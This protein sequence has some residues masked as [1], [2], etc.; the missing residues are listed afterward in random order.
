MTLKVHPELVTMSAHA[1]KRHALNIQCCAEL[2]LL[3]TASKFHLGVLDTSEWVDVV[4]GAEHGGTLML[5]DAAEVGDIDPTMSMSQIYRSPCRGGTPVLEAEAEGEVGNYACPGPLLY[6]CLKPDIDGILMREDVAKVGAFDSP[7][8][9]SYMSPRLEAE[10]ESGDYDCLGP[11]SEGSLERG[12]I[13]KLEDEAEAGDFVSPAPQSY[14]WLEDTWR[15]EP[16]QLKCRRKSDD[17]L[18]KL[19]EGEAPFMH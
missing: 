15:I 10:A 7:A 19:G 17:E 11:P 4:D 2:P 9:R 14:G 18:W 1:L 16:H 5:E 6:G 12:G 8:S 3:A 13:L